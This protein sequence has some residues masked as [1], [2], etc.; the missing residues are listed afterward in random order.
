[1][2][3]ITRATELIYLQQWA[4]RAQEHQQKC[5]K[6]LDEFQDIGSQL[7]VKVVITLH[8]VQE[9]QQMVDRKATEEHLVQ[10]MMRNCQNTVAKV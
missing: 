2:V 9:S 8:D 7:A 3:Q 4:S 5:H 1:M 10:Q 6:Q